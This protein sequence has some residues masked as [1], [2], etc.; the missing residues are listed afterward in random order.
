MTTRRYVYE[1][2]ARPSPA[3]NKYP[4]VASDGI[5]TRKVFI[6]KKRWVV[7]WEFKPNA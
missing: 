7:Q 1:L 2:G 4:R 6:Y 5:T 3:E